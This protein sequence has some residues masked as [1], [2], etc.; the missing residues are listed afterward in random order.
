MQIR[1][2]DPKSVIGEHC[3]GV[4]Y[5]YQVSKPEPN[6][7]SPLT[8]RVTQTDTKSVTKCDISISNRDDQQK[9]MLI[10]VISLQTGLKANL[11]DLEGLRRNGLIDFYELRN[12]NSEVILYWRGMRPK[13][14]RRVELAFLREFS[15]KNAYPMLVSSYLYYDKSGSMVCQLA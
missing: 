2:R 3:F 1:P 10:C 6:P 5:S 13:G 15:V 11:N 9:G 8:L 4:S 12:H 14:T 7:E